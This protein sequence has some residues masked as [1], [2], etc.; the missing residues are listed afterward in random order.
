[1][2]TLQR[3]YRVDGLFLA[4]AAPLTTILFCAWVFPGA[5]CDSSDK[6]RGAKRPPH[7][8]LETDKHG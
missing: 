1:M 8:R 7:V 3:F 5:D 6:P 4:L 2:A